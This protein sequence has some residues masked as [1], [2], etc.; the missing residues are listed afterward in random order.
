H[1][2]VKI[3]FGEGVA[4]DLASVLAEEGA[5]KPLVVIDEGLAGLVP[6]VAEALGAVA[7][8]TSFEKAPGEP[9][10]ALVEQAAEALQTAGCDAVVAI[11][12]G[13]AARAGRT[14]ASPGAA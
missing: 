7:G 2:P 6:R 12:G 11:G 8:A 5:A 10:V 13:S 1:L 14:C 4:A 3:R 9:T